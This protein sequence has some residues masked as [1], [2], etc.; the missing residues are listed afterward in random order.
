[1]GDS[2][3]QEAL[4]STV[5]EKV[6]RW[7][8]EFVGGY[9]VDK[10]G[11]SSFRFGSARIFVGVEPWA[12]ENC[13]VRVG[14]AVLMDVPKSPELNEWIAYNTGNY[15]FGTISLSED[16][17][18]T[19]NANVLIDHVVLGDYIDLE[20][21]R[22]AVGAVATTADELDTELKAKFGGNTFHEDQD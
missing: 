15:I 11:R 18:D 12:D 6:N 14:T 2:P 3:A 8:A 22:S 20:E 16:S 7:L 21:F 17:D 13:L 4:V 19:S 10:S 1:M 5:T 9:Q